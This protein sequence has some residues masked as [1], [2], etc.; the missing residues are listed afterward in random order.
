MAID[1]DVN[2]S[3]NEQKAQIPR[4]SGDGNAV[5]PQIIITPRKLL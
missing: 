4:S 3:E 2:V 1:S 5:R